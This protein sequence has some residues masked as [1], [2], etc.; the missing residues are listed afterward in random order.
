MTKPLKNTGSPALD[1]H[2]LRVTHD[3]VRRLHAGKTVSVGG[4]ELTRSH[5][6]FV[7][8]RYDVDDS[9]KLKASMLPGL[10]AE[11]S[12]IAQRLRADQGARS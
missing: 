7:C 8:T 9:G 2:E 6:S 3:D 10:A 4:V 12:D 1:G 11:L 5:L